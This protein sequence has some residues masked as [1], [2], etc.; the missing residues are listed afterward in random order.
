VDMSGNPARASAVALPGTHDRA[1][2]LRDSISISHQDR[3]SCTAIACRRRVRPAAPAPHQPAP[4]RR[5]VRTST[6]TG[7]FLSARSLRQI[8]TTTARSRARSVYNWVANMETETI[9]MLPY[10]DCRAGRGITSSSAGR[11][12]EAE[13]RLLRDRLAG[14]E[15]GRLRGSEQ[16]KSLRKTDDERIASR[17]R[18]SRARAA[19]MRFFKRPLDCSTR[20]GR[21]HAVGRLQRSASRSRSKR[22]ARPKAKRLQPQ[23]G[24]GRARA[25]AEGAGPRRPAGLAIAEMA[26]RPPPRYWCRR[27]PGCTFASRYAPK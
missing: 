26:L 18:S 27:L 4:R 9:E 6:E 24:R 17:N 23:A 5:S 8:P 3:G 2:I 7:L 1:S 16:F 10:H 25:L 14:D 21:H 22:S 11:P 15:R 20:R 13:G 12:L 19:S